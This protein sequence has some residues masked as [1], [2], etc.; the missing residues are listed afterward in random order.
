MKGDD[1]HGNH[2]VAIDVARPK[3]NSFVPQ[4]SPSDLVC[5][6]EKLIDSKTLDLQSEK[7]F[8]LLIFLL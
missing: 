1:A 4:V 5:D 6:S 8:T 2:R 7:I 3:R